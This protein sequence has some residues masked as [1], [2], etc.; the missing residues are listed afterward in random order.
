[1]SLSLKE[2][3]DWYEYCHLP[4]QCMTCGTPEDLSVDHIVPRSIQRLGTTPE[5]RAN[6][7]YRRAR[8]RAKKDPRGFQGYALMCKR[9]NQMKASLFLKDFV[10]HIK[11]IYRFLA[12]KKKLMHNKKHEQI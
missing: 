8:L 9:C 12:H 2:L 6:H 7:H 10:L 1:M 5:Q 11:K 4:V 3:I